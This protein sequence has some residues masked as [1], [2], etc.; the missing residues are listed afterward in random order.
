MIGGCAHFVG[1]KT[2]CNYPYLYCGVIECNGFV[3]LIYIR[4]FNRVAGLSFY[5]LLALKVSM[6][7]SERLFCQEDDKSVTVKV[8]RGLFEFPLWNIV[9]DMF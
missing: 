5:V 9:L 1:S 6:S 2:S 3:L 7:L 4:C 8:I